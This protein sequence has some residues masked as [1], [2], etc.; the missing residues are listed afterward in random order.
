MK[1]KVYWD[2]LH[3]GDAIPEL[4][5]SPTTRQLV[6]Y[7]GAS[8]DYYEIHYDKD[9]ALNNNLPGPILHGALKNAFLG[10]LIT[11]WISPYGALLKLSCQYRGMDVPGDEISGRGTITKK[12]SLNNQNLI[13][14]EIW[15]ENPK[16][17]KT[18]PG[19]ATLALPKNKSNEVY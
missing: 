18:T 17:E 1:Q 2:D 10:Q 4:I 14:C 3:E 7:A 12:Y 5:K 6:M 11:E 19:S 13:D 9:Y 16:R 8:G 15:L